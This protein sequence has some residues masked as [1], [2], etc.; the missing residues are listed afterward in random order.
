MGV[1]VAGQAAHVVALGVHLAQA[2]LAHPGL[3]DRADRMGRW[4]GITRFFRLV[5]CGCL[6]LVAGLIWDHIGPMYV[7]LA[8]IAIDV[9][10]RL[11]LLVTMPETLTLKLQS[12]KTAG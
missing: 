4:L 1:G 9:M 6:V 5:S 3:E 10:V 2:D 11:P 8:F 7:F 12:D